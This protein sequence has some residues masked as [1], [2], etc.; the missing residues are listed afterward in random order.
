MSA[1]IVYA[2]SERREVY[3][4]GATEEWFQFEININTGRV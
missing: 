3:F 4:P 2:N 1:P